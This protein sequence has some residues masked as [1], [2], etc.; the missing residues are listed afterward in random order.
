MQH[1]KVVSIALALMGI[2]IMASCS[3]SGNPAITFLSPISLDT[4]GSPLFSL[5]PTDTLPATT[6]GSDASP[7][8]PSVSPTR[9][10][11]VSNPCI[12]PGQLKDHLGSNVCIKG[13]MLATDNWG[14]DF[15]MWL[16]QDPATEYIVVHN[17]FY[18]GVEGSCLRVTG[19]VEKDDEARF[20]IRADDPGQVSPCQ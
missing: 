10:P 18:L 7:V 3:S 6:K 15:V 14:N 11:P 17:T 2:T 9:I 4:T 19:V 8:P 13:R 5:G 1:Q 12:S 16:D 20:F